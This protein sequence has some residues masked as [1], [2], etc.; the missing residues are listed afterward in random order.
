MY[1]IVYTRQGLIKNKIAEKAGLGEKVSRLLD[2]LKD[3][4]FQTYPPEKLVGNFSGAYSRR[5][6]RQHRLVYRVYE[7]E[8]IV[9]VISVWT[10]S[11]LI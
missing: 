8:K 1:K 2:V 11:E 7:E 6:N 3:D 5:I 10:H 4:P 9:K